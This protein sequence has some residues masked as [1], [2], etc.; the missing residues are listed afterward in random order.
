MAGKLPSVRSTSTSGWLRKRMTFDVGGGMTEHE[1]F[2]CLILRKSDA[3]LD[4]ASQITIT[5]LTTKDSQRNIPNGPDMMEFRL[6]GP[7]TGVY[8]AGV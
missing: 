8:E 5:V 3:G 2:R 7:G 4:F 1:T 6:H